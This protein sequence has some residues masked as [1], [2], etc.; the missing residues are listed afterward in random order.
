MIY[1]KDKNIYIK[2]D[3]TFTQIQQGQK[4]KTQY[5]KKFVNV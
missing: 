3:S 2:N 5:I 4:N 1:G